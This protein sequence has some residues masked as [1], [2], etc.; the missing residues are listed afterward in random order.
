MNRTLVVF[1]VA[2]LIL[3]PLAAQNHVETVQR[4]LQLDEGQAQELSVLI[5]SWREVIAPLRRE[6]RELQGRARELLGEAN[7]DPTA[8]GLNQLAIQRL[9]REIA[10]AEAECRAQFEGLLKSEQQETYERII[11]TA[12]ATRRMARIIPAFRELG[13]LQGT[14][15]Q[16]LS[17]IRQ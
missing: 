3:A 9:R 7:P 13:L 5:Q 1:F 16:P 6:V 10:G 4:V 15:Q 12:L 11:R 8:I 14:R 2:F 17:T